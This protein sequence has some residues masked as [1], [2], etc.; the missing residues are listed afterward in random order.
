MFVFGLAL[1]LASGGVIQKYVGT[2]AALAYAPLCAVAALCAAPL[3]RTTRRVPT[4]LAVAVLVVVAL[5][6]VAAVIVVFPHANAH[7]TDVGSDRDDAATIG[8]RSLLDGDYPY[9]QRTYLGNPISQ[10]P[11]GLLAAIPFVQVTGSSGYEVVLWLPLLLILLVRVARSAIEAAAVVLLVLALS[12]GLW[13]DLLTGGD[14]IPCVTAVCVCLVFFE[15]A[16]SWPLLGLA[17]CWR[18]NL[19]VSA[20]PFLLRLSPAR[21]IAAAALATVTFLVATLPLALRGGFTPWAAG[22]K[23]E[24]Y[25]GVVP[26]GGWLLLLVAL[27]VTVLLAWRKVGDVWAQAAWPQAL[28]VAAFVV[29]ACADAG[30][31]DLTPLISGY[32]ILVLV[33]A[34]FS[35]AARGASAREGAIAAAAVTNINRP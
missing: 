13:R 1:W 17:V 28:F 22:N 29:K 10:F 15:R 4:R 23:L 24:S 25:N 21:A 5:V 18:P 33:P 27:A 6:V 31:L 16:W 12:P 14:L 32:G 2:A 34:M 35:V 3:L 7:G 30:R 8:A 19:A 20:V 26:G 9:D 11:V